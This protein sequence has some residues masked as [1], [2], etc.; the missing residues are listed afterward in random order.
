MENGKQIYPLNSKRRQT[1]L[2]KWKKITWNVALKPA[3]VRSALID[4]QAK[5]LQNLS[6]ERQLR[7]ELENQVAHLEEENATLEEKQ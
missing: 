5:L 3:E 6:Q 7:S 1:L 4:K 2:D